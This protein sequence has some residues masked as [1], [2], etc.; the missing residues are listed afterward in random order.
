[1]VGINLGETPTANPEVLEVSMSDSRPRIT[2]A[3]AVLAAALGTLAFFSN[4]QGTKPSPAP[5]QPRPSP[6][7]P[8]PNYPPGLN[9]PAVKGPDPKSIDKANLAELQNDV[10]KLYALVFVLRE[11]MKMTD[12]TST[13]SVALVKQAQQIEK[14]AKEIKDRAKR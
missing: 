4:A 13:M 2:I 12:S 14:L 11:Q 3:V 7:V 10:E 5:P 1:M 8:N 9:G 6:N